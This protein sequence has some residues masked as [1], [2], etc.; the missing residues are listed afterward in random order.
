MMRNTVA[1]S[2]IEQSQL[3]PSTICLTTF[4]IMRVVRSYSL[5]MDGIVQRIFVSVLFVLLAMHAGAQAKVAKP[6]AKS[7]FISTDPVT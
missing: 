2:S 1:A 3:S 5:K 7:S 6:Q 4:L